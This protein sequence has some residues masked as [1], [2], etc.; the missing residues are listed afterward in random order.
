M[1][2]FLG[3][4]LLTHAAIVNLIAA[5]RTSTGLRV[6]CVL[7]RRRYPRGVTVTDDEMAGVRLIRDA[8]HGDWNYTIRPALSRCPR[9]SAHVI[10]PCGSNATSLRPERFV[11]ATD[12][13]RHRADCTRHPRAASRPKRRPDGTRVVPPYPK[14]IPPVVAPTGSQGPSGAAVVV[15]ERGKDKHLTLRRPGARPVRGC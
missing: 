13:G 4:P 2:R 14:R 6:R 8:F 1:L 12:A 11:R 7:E 10:D 9:Q 5:T 3:K 15:K